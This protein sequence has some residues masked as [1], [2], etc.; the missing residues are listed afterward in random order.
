RKRV[1]ELMPSP[2]IGIACERELVSGIRDVE[3]K[4]PVNGQQNPRPNG[5]CKDTL[6]DV[7]ELKKAVEFYLGGD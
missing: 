5:P 4:I 7:E 3:N 6:I 1:K 2:K